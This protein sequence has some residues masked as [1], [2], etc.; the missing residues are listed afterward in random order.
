MEQFDIFDQG[1]NLI[2]TASRKEAHEKGLWHQAFHCWIAQHDKLVFQLRGEDKDT[3]PSMLD[4]TV[5][6]HL[7]AGETV[8]DGVR[9]IKEEIGVDVEFDKLLSL[10]TR[11]DV[12][13]GDT[14]INCEFVDV[15]LLRSDRPLD[16]Y[17]LQAEEVTG[18]VAIDIAA[19]LALFSGKQISTLAEA[20]VLENGQL[21][22]KRLPISV[23][24]FIPR[25]DQYYF[26][27]F[28]LARR[29]SNK[30]EHLAI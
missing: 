9:E 12:A 23:K 20:V 14:F 7:S 21:V 29:S 19:G 3:F 30:N 2:G 28:D 27:M 26:K 25:H 18:L 4:A 8:Q 1:R 10:G 5:G 16:D 15:F 17:V 24:D 22:K 13:K 6:G 11:I